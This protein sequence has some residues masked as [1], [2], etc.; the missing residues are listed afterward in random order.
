MPPDQGP[1]GTFAVI[2]FKA[3]NPEVPEAT[4]PARTLADTR[5]IGI[6]LSSDP[7]ADR[8]GME[9]KLPDGSWH[10]F[11]GNQIAAVLC[12]FL[13]LD[14]QGPQ[15]KG[16]VIETLVTTKILGKIVEKA[17]ESWIVDDLLVGFK[18]VADVLK[19]LERG[20][21]YNGVRCAPQQLVLAAEESHGVMLLPTIRDKD[22]APACMFLAALYQRLHS[23]G[24]TILDYYIQ[25]LEELGGYADVNRSIMMVGSG[26]DVEERS[27]HG[28]PQT[29]ASSDPR[30]TTRQQGDGLLGSASV[31]TI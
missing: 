7:D 15:R 1:D 27:H 25:I 24:R 26:R 21:S 19:R 8:V 20:E 9:I 3:P 18:Y 6:V 12:Y 22:S 4:S 11:D 28:V 5:G 10:H 13:M 23:E 29:H 31:W 16:L 30:W 14:P 2:P 17:G